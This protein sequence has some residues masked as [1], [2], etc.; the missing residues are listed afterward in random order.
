MNEVYLV[1]NTVNGKQYVGVTSKGYLNRFNQHVREAYGNTH[2]SLFHQALK[3]Y[4]KLAFSIQLIEENISDN[5][6]K[7]KERFYIK[8]YNTFYLNHHGYNMTEGGDGMSGYCH[9]VDTK[10]RISKTLQGHIFPKERNLKIKKAMLGREYKP[11][12]RDALSRS[13]MGRF[14]G[15]NNPFYGKHHTDTTK[16]KISI[17]NSKNVILQLDSKTNEVLQEFRNYCEAARWIIDNNLSTALVTTCAARLRVVTQST[18]SLCTAYGYR[19]R[20][21]EGQ[22]T[23][24]KTEDELLFEVQPSVDNTDKI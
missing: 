12:W 18:N 7:D 20:V 5:D 10:N 1:T 14:G 4:G 24:S 11:E 19:W 6:I 2:N 9:T 22:S 21:K 3:K 16:Q 13:R 15:E 17:A 23:I 8:K